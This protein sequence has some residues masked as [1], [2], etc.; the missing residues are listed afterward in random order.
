MNGARAGK[1]VPLVRRRGRRYWVLLLLLGLITGVIVGFVHQYEDAYV[2][3]GK[4]PAIPVFMYH[5]DWLRDSVM[6]ELPDFGLRDPFATAMNFAGWDLWQR[7]IVIVLMPMFLI[8]FLFGWRGLI[9]IVPYMG[10]VFSGGETAWFTSEYYFIWVAGYYPFEPMYGPLRGLLILTLGPVIAPL[11]HCSYWIPSA[12]FY[13]LL[14]LAA[15]GLVHMGRE[16][17][18]DRKNRGISLA[19]LLPMGNNNPRPT[20]D[21]PSPPS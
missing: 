20:A 11:F 5:D 18:R 13:G 6:R 9:A 15:R 21:P 16:M 8:P 10:G 17:I 2:H 4:T 14:G 1:R 12:I 3:R 7:D 19:D